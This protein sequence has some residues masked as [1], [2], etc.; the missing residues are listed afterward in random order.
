MIRFKFNPAGLIML[1]VTIVVVIVG[2][3][4][5]AM[6]DQLL[7][8]LVGGVLVLGDMALRLRKRGQG[9]W[10]FQPEAG[11]HLFSVPVWIV[12][13]VIFLINLFVRLT[14]ARP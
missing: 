4:V 14:G 2:T 13:A 6:Q 12:G 3:S 11:G 1:A 10:L 8:M 7:M 5:F 9:R